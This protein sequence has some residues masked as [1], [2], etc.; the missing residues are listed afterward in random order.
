MHPIVNFLKTIF[1]WVPLLAATAVLPANCASAAELPVLQFVTLVD[2]VERPGLFQLF[3]KTNNEIC[4]R[5]QY[6][7]T[8]KYYPAARAAAMVESGEADGENYRV[9][10]FAAD[11]KNPRHIRVDT[12]LYVAT[13]VAWGKPGTARVSSWDEV[14]MQGQ[15]V[16]YLFGSK[17]VVNNLGARMSSN[18]TPTHSVESGLNMLVADRASY[19]I[20]S[21]SRGVEQKISRLRLDSQI[22]KM[23]IVESLDTYLY[24][25]DK[26][27]A[28]AVKF[29]RTIEEMKK[30]GSLDTLMF[31]AGEIKAKPR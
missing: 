8:L 2:P 23:G 3:E 29:K 21:D 10:N 11:G 7:C 18:L 16:M 4:R 13:F 22:T 28:L 20:T 31:E 9:F 26:H 27:R 1:I 25:N 12:P 14:A 17:I 19:F 30:D 24:M 6:S 15:P 5:L